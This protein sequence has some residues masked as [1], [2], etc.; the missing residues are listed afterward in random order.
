MPTWPKHPCS[1]YG[2]PNLVE[3]GHRFCEVHEKQENRNYEKYG[4]KYNAKHRYGSAWS[5]ISYKYRGEHP[6]CEVCLSKGIAVE[7][8][9]VHHKIPIAEGGTNAEDNLQALCNSCHSKI[10]AERG[11]RWHR[12]GA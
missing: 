2:C 6:L 8:E 12:G 3:K 10:H 9:L 11:D 7:S 1:R 5:R 4:R